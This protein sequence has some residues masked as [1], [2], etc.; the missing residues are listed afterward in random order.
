MNVTT[1]SPGG[2]AGY[3][4]AVD[5]RHSPNRGGDRTDVWR[6]V[7]PARQPARS[8]GKEVIAVEWVMPDFEEFETEAEVT[9]YA[10][11]W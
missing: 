7:H 6:I 2:G 5:A 4:S 11:H 1:C 10:Y 8:V 3:N 9:A